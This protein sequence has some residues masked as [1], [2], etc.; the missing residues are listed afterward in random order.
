MLKLYK[1]KETEIKE[2]VKSMVILVDTREKETH[3]TDFFDKKKIV[4]KSKKL[5]R[6][7]YS[8]MI[9]ANPDLDI[10]RD[11]YFDNEVIIERK[12]SLEEISGNLTNGRDRF[13][14][15]LALSPKD[16]VLLLEGGGFSDIVSGNYN[17]KYSKKSF[18]ASL[19]TFWFRYN[20]PIFFMPDKKYSGIFVKLFFEYYLKGEL[21]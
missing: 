4:W 21:N 17:T 5:D 16:K 18:L 10:P 19:F 1:Y 11:L 2:I 8:F 3:I 15:E 14:K 9:P 20:M 6:G 13:E 7:D 12:G